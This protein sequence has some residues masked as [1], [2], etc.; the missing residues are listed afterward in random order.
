MS[1][2]ASSNARDFKTVDVD[3][4]KL[5]INVYKY[6]SI[7]RAAK[8]LG[9]RY[10]KAWN[11]VKRVGDVINIG[12]VKKGGREGGG[13][14][15][16]ED[17]LKLLR[18]ALSQYHKIFAGE[19]KD[20]YPEARNIFLYYRGS[21]D[22][23]FNYLI[24]ALEE[25]KTLVY[26][27]WVGSLAGIASLTLGESDFAGIHI[28]NSDLIPSNIETLKMF[29]LENKVVVVKGYE[30]LQG[31]FL[32]RSTMDVEDILRGVVKGEQVIALRPP[33]TGTR[34]LFNALL[35]KYLGK[36][37]IEEKGATLRTVELKTHNDVAKAVSENEADVGIGI[38]CLSKMY[39]IKFVPIA[40]ESF[41]FVFSLDSVDIEFVKRFASILKDRE[42][43]S[44]I[45]S[46]EGYR[47]PKNIGEIIKL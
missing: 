7:N 10:S 16:S 18:R 4:L 24:K 35:R 47:A 33:A 9:M 12:Y 39:N 40:W 42:F 31:F 23:A 19:F 17:A 27:E 37:R 36:H 6:G 45:E 28:V 2:N 34:L 29:G 22:I 11:L 30:R 38:A 26:A 25:S 14:I 32:K 8:A 3:V 15:L 21:H 46:L 41:D 1:D 20:L 5:L 44:I 43:I 13:V